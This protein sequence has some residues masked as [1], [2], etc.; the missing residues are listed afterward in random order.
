MQPLFG[1]TQAGRPC[2]RLRHAREEARETM[3]RRGHTRWRRCLPAGSR[4]RPKIW[5][6]RNGTGW[7]SVRS[8]AIPMHGH[9]PRRLFRGLIPFAFLLLLVVAASGRAQ[10]PLSDP[11]DLEQRVKAAYLYKF[12]GYVEWPG[13]A[14]PQPESPFTIAIADDERVAKALEEIVA[15]RKV[16][17]RNVQVRRVQSGDEP[18]DAHILFLGKPGA[19]APSQAIAKPKPRPMLVVSQS[20]DAIAQ[21]SV[22]NFALS[23]G[24]VR[25][26]VSLD[27]AEKRGLKLSS[28]LLAVAQQVHGSTQ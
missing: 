27:A 23:E 14:F 3:L 18:A 25:F 9:R 15:G 2:V 20:A 22:I 5:L 19:R 4:T 26:E 8:L 10:T 28:R 7:P 24:K 16:E 17:G 21:G 13:D 1:K 11:P 6:S 12:A